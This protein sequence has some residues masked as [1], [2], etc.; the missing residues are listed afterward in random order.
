MEAK[1]VHRAAILHHHVRGLRPCEI[2]KALK[3]LNVK[4]RTIYDVVKRYTETGS[5]NDKKRSGRPRSARTPA[6]VK[7]L[8][9]R[10]R[11]N[12][13]RTQKKL[14]L[15]MKVSVDSIARALQHDIGV[16]A[17]RRG[18]CHML[19]VAQ[20]KKR[21]EKCRA[22]LKRYAGESLH[23]ILFT[24]EK[25]F[26][27]EEKFNRQNDRIYAKRKSDIPIAARKSK[28]SHHPGS[29]MVWLGVSW[30]GK[31]E[32][33]FVPQGV[34]VRAK[35]YLE[36]VLEPIVKPLGMSLFNGKHWTFQQD[37]A[38]AHGAKIIQTWLKN[39]IPDFIS[40]EE[41]P[42]ASPDLN[43]LDDDLWSK[44]ETMACSKPHNSVDALKS[45]L[46]KTWDKFPMEEVRAAI[47]Q[48][49][50]RLRQCVKAKGGNF[51]N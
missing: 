4:R 17:L 19:T 2:F 5:T 33:Y 44:L 26:T 13:R 35:N 10:I 16:K 21:V 24:D 12:P 14:A 6:M 51:E 36:S 9:A 29:V 23:R 50:V 34:K 43:P 20:K 25:I 8:K 11:R 46:V 1:K 48:W 37:S 7:A 28:K 40:K 15:Q 30:I 3:N 39:N 22:L 32:L 41:W 47:D 42:S 38:P 31:A 27:V 18:T 49:P 45:S